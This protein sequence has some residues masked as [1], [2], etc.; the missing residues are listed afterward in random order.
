M[1]LE[2]GRANDP[3]VRRLEADVQSMSETVDRLLTLGR[4]ESIAGP[5]RSDIDLPC[6]LR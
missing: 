1:M 3:R 2:L 6:T 4:L 5:E